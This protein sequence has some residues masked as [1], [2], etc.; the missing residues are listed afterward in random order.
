[1]YEEVVLK[2]FIFWQQLIIKYILEGSGGG[3]KFSQVSRLVNQA[4]FGKFLFVF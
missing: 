1:M 2:H 3:R 4:L